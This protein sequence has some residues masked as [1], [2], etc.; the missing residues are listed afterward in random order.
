MIRK[1]IDRNAKSITERQDLYGQLCPSAKSRCRPLDE[2]TVKKAQEIINEN[3]VDFTPLGLEFLA[4]L[5]RALKCAMD[6]NISMTE[7]K[8]RMTAPVMELKANAAIFHYPLVGNLANIMLSFLEAI[9][10][11]DKDAIEIVAAHHTTLN[12]IIVKKMSGDGGKHGAILIR[13][14]KDACARYYAKKRK[15]A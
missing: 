5:D 6:D 14:L 12:A 7:R 11:L 9:E 3:K 10:I 4:K 15:T 1:E 8:Q 13:E 2:A